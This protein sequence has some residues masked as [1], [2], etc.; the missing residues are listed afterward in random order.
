MN[1]RGVSHAHELI[2]LVK[3]DRWNKMIN[4]QKQ[5][6]GNTNKETKLA[7]LSNSFQMSEKY[8]HYTQ[9][10]LRILWAFI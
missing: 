9:P 7:G 4:I 1:S 2:I 3:E 8:K 10:K 6:G 5:E